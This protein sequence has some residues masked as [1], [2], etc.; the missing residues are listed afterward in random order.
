MVQF[1]NIYRKILIMS[2]RGIGIQHAIVYYHFVFFL[3][4]VQEKL[5][6]LTQQLSYGMNC[7]RKLSLKALLKAIYLIKCNRV[8]SAIFCILKCKFLVV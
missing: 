2:V 3:L 6:L 8:I 1:E 4:R 5:H 7:L